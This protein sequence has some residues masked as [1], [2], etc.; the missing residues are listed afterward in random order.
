MN[1]FLICATCIFVGLLILSGCADGP[2]RNIEKK[3][4]VTHS[5]LSMIESDEVQIIAS[6]T[7]QT[8]TWVSTDP[9]VASV[10]PTGLVR[11]LRDGV[12]FI[13]V[14]SSGG[15]SRTIPVDVITLIPLTGIDVINIANIHQPIPP[16]S[17]LLGQTVN[18]EAKP[19][20][21]NYNEKIPFNVTWVSSNEDII[22]VDEKGAVK[23]M[24]FGSAEII[25]KV[26]DKPS[27]SKVIPIDVPEIPI[28]EIRISSSSLDLHV[29]KTHV[30]TTSFL[31]T[32]YSVKDETLV[33]TSTNP[34]VASVANGTITAVSFGSTVIRVALNADATVFNEVQVKVQDASI[35]GAPKYRR[36][37]D[38]VYGADLCFTNAP[39]LTTD[40]NLLYA[41][42]DFTKGG[43]IDI[44]GLDA[45]TKAAVYNRDFM[46][47]D[48]VAETL[49]FTGETGTWDV[50]YSHLYK[51]FWIR[52]NYA[53]YPDCIW[54]RGQGFS[55]AAT[56]HPDLQGS[57]GGYYWGPGKIRFAAFMKRIDDDVYQAHI[58]AG[59]S[60]IGWMNV[61]KFL[62]STQWAVGAEWT[63][64]VPGD[65]FS[66]MYGENILS[67][68]ATTGYYRYTVDLNTMTK[69]LEKVN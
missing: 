55:Q 11:A 60:G 57:S 3:I 53:D 62:H 19:D 37:M 28:Q 26:V 33:W 59:T 30:I 48:P 61:V 5:E 17:M 39:Q 16:L 15:L 23:A 34:S 38:V 36:N 41:Q 64:D 49:T 13:E 63:L 44:P 2:D 31:P 45:A 52:Q 50:Y 27:I 29:E 6:P 42:V 18:L 22:M 8:F 43:L 25:V 66:Q 7:S 4:F 58:Y 65:G 69:T 12:C 35:T 68:P 9:T 1:K 54:G 14:T 32:D 47:W 10:S 21:A 46:D 51:Y 67:T 40:D 20:P 24:D 56:W